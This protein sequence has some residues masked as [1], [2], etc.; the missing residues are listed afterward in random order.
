M[1]SSL[2]FYFPVWD[3]LHFE[4]VYKKKR[5][6]LLNHPYWIK[7][8]IGQ[9]WG[10]C[11]LPSPWRSAQLCSIWKTRRDQTL[12]YITC[13]KDVENKVHVTVSILRILIHFN[14]CI[15]DRTSEMSQNCRLDLFCILYITTRHDGLCG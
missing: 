8:Q 5:E 2:W 6:I 4:C 3:H 12:S 9:R 10:I 14:F 1:H 11:Y 13:S 15:K 7:D